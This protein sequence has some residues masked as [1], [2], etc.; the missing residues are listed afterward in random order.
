[1]LWLAAGCEAKVAAKLSSHPLSAIQLQ[2][3][4]GIFRFLPT[5]HVEK[6]ERKQ[7]AFTIFPRRAA[8]YMCYLHALSMTAE[9]TH[10]MNHGF[11][12]AGKKNNK[13][14]Q[15]PMPGKDGTDSGIS[16]LYLYL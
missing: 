11:L 15:I 3:G 8:F 7:N 5:T 2:T 6:G 14:I 12:I 1:M 9:H 13:Y 4:I 10:L 16:Y